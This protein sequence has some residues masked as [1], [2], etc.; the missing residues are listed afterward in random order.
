MDKT[1]ADR[2]ITYWMKNF[3]FLA[4]GAGAIL[5]IIT[6]GPFLIPCRWPFTPGYTYTDVDYRGLQ[7]PANRDFAEFLERGGW[8][9]LLHRDPGYVYATKDVPEQKRYI[10]SDGKVLLAVSTKNV[11]QRANIGIRIEGG[12]EITHRE[13]FEGIVQ[14]L[15]RH[16]DL[17][18]DPARFNFSK[19]CVL[20][21]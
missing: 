10:F 13:L 11:L 15:N 5:L 7:T 14:D 18:L 20:G 4:L 1:D 9:V 19:S 12:S 3:V 17:G 16:F 6:I 2:S 21:P 8:D